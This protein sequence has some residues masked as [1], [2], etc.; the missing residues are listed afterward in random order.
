MTTNK[1][2]KVGS[3]GSALALLQNE[4]VLSLLRPLHPDLDFEVVRV[5]TQGDANPN[6]ALTGLGLGVFVT[7]IERQ[8]QVGLLDMAIH[9]L[10]DLP[11]QIPPDLALGAVLRRLDPRDVL[12]NRWDCS[13]VELPQG[14]RIGTSSPR[15]QALLRTLCPQV[16]PVPIRGNVETRLRKAQGEECDG[17]ILAAAGMAR[18]GLSHQITEYL[19][20]QRFVPPP[21]QGALAIEIRADDDKMLE[22]LRP[23]EDIETRLAVTAERGFLEKLGGGC[24]LPVGAYARCQEELMLMT[25]FICSADGG[26]VF[27]SKLEGLALDPLQMASDAYL[28]VVERGGI[29]LHDLENVEQHKFGLEE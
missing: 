12:V 11:T 23:I 14:A 4:E 3:R 2:I 24:Q 22:L 1:V 5:R 15:R 8:L 9:S 13:L 27:R 20:A 6:A 26:K 29:E 10:K 16:I 21:G 25:L 19:S 7:E 17:A 28:A 18:L